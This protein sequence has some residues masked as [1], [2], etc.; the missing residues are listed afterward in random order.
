VTQVLLV[1]AL[2]LASVVV[3]EVEVVADLGRCHQGAAFQ[4]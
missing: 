1:V 3:M 2:V 4:D